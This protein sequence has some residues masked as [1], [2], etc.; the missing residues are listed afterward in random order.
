MPDSLNLFG[1]TP[2]GAAVASIACFLGDCCLTRNA[3]LL[4]VFTCCQVKLYCVSPSRDRCCCGGGPLATLRAL[5]DPRKS[6]SPENSCR[7]PLT[8]FSQGNSLFWTP[9]IFLTVL[10]MAKR[11]A[12]RGR[13]SRTS[14]HL[15][16]VLE[17]DIDGGAGPNRHW[18][19]GMS[20]P[21]LRV[22]GLGRLTS[23]AERG[24]WSATAATCLG[25]T[26]CQPFYPVQA[27]T[28]CGQSA[29]G[30]CRFRPNWPIQVRPPSSPT[31]KSCP[32][33]SGP[34]FITATTSAWRRHAAFTCPRMH[35]PLPFGG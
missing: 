20:R 15:F 7:G 13:S 14:D 11:A 10:W 29:L 21:K 28:T 23:N 2:N 24:S 31:R 18:V 3:K 26:A 9:K 27:C 1:T 35:I 6:L 32:K 17:S 4:I 22:V 33:E 12:T 34:C 8:N 16:S 19:S 25:Q 30:Q 5:T